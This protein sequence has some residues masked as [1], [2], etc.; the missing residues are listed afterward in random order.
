[1]VAVSRPPRV[2][3]LR[4]VRTAGLPLWSVAAPVV[5]LCVSAALA[6]HLIVA[7]VGKLEAGEPGAAASVVLGC[8][9]IL[10]ILLPFT[11]LF[12]SRLRKLSKMPDDRNLRPSVRIVWRRRR[13]LR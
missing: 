12:A 2:L 4:N 9:A 3:V 6:L 1:M 7:I 5:G 11:I 8:G 13:L 10:L